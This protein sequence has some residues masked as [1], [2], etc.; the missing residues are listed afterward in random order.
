MRRRRAKEK[1]LSDATRKPGSLENRILGGLSRKEYARIAPDLRHV[2]LEADQVLY[3]P[4]DTMQWA[5]FLDT[6]SVSILSLAE[7]GTS[8]EVS[9]VG[10]EGVIGIPIVLR[11]LSLPYQVV[12]QGPGTARRMK[13][14][15]LRKEFDRCA[16]LHDLLLQYVHTEIVQLAQSGACNRFH[17]TRQRLCRWL[18]ASQD[19]FGSS[20]LRSTQEFLARMLGVNRGSA[21]QAA[22]SLQRAGLIRY[23]RGRISILNR[24]GLETA[25]C[26]CYRII[27]TETARF[28]PG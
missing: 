24:S 3:E 16:Q 19:L 26:E 23:R 14:G 4:G 11:S 22:A 17:T 21:N 27:K 28:F 25:A 8:I 20:E 7:N 9:L 13:A 18:L 2:T 6:A 12:V 15:V 5:Y 10:S 1:V